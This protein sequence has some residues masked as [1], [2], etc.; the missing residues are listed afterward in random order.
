M[1]KARPRRMCLTVALSTA[2]WFGPLAHRE[3]V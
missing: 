1:Q 2:L 3:A